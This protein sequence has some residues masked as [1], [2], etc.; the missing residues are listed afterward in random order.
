[1]LD[2]N[3]VS[4]R[5]FSCQI[6]SGESEFLKFNH[7]SGMMLELKNFACNNFGED[8]SLVKKARVHSRLDGLSSSG[9]LYQNIPFG[10]EFMIKRNFEF[11]SNFAR[12]ISD[13]DPGAGAIEDLKLEDFVLSGDFEE[14]NLFL[15]NGNQVELKSFKMSD[16]QEIYYQ[17]DLPI[18]AFNVVDKNQNKFEVGTGNDLWRHNGAKLYPNCS[19]EFKLAG[20]KDKVTL[21]RHVIKFNS[22][23][24]APRK[25]AWRFKYYF[26]W[27]SNFER[28]TAN[29]DFELVDV[30]SLFDRSYEHVNNLQNLP[31]MTSALVRRTLRNII[32]KSTKSLIIDCDLALCEDSSH[33]ERV[34]AETLLHWSIDDFF[35]LALWGSQIMAKSDLQLKFAPNKSQFS[36][37][38][39]L[40]VLTKALDNNIEIG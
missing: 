18:L 36:K 27:S 17:A 25:R 3:T 16:K 10:C 33:L 26:A 9:E 22:S 12:I 20:N 32:R 8:G 7:S 31:C 19:S 30:K 39:A 14:L 6:I 40:E 35:E 37:L 11:T 34:N 23:E 5:D 2:E 1:M 28:Q 29:S 13:I 4:G 21:E 24:D 38:V 15:L